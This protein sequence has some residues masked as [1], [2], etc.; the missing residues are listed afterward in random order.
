MPVM[1]DAEPDARK[2]NPWDGTWTGN[3]G[4]WTAELTITDGKFLLD[5]SCDGPRGISDRVSGSIDETGRI[6][7]ILQPT[8]WRG[9]TSVSGIPEALKFTPRWEAEAECAGAARLS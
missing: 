7:A 8:T 9:G 4:T 3:N 5:A 1:P 6:S 2:E